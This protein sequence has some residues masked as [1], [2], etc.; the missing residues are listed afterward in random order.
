MLVLRTLFVVLN[1]PCE[2]TSNKFRCFIVSL[3]GSQSPQYRI[4]HECEPSVGNFSVEIGDD[5]YSW[6]VFRK[7]FQCPRK[8][9]MIAA[10]IGGD[11]SF[12]R[13]MG[14]DYNT[15]VYGCDPTIGL[16]R[17]VTEPSHGFEFHPIGLGEKDGLLKFV[18]KAR[19]S[20]SQLLSRYEPE[21]GDKLIDVQMKSVPTILEDLK[22][23][24][25][26]D[27]LKLDIEGTEYDVLNAV[28]ESNLVIGQILVEFHGRFIPDVSG[29]KITRS[30]VSKLSSKG[31]YEFYNSNEDYGFVNC[32]NLR[33]LC[34]DIFAE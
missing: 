31:F 30:M 32:D 18:K 21:K 19:A 16:P 14:S 15:L 28:L 2:E 10:G 5:G 4:R 12:E 7:A 13:D 20:S 34:L 9:K 24:N 22:W 8:L 29:E 17:S 6:H 25:T 11:N 1:G 33:K 26:L 27:I 3:F 23:G